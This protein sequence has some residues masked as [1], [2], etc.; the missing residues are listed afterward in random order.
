[1]PNIPVPDLAAMNYETIAD[2]I[3]TPTDIPTYMTGKQSG[4]YYGDELSPNTAHTNPY[5]H[6]K[7]N[8]DLGTDGSGGKLIVIKGNL[9][10]HDT[11]SLFINM[12][13]NKNQRVTIVVEGNLYIA[14]DLSY[15]N[16]NSAV[17]F[18]VKGNDANPESYVDTNRNYRYDPGESI[19]NDNG[20]GVYEGPIEGQ[21]NV[22]FGDPRFGTGG[23]TDGFIYAQNN[24]YLVNPPNNQGAVGGQDAIF[25]V[26]GFLSAGG[27]M[28]LGNRTAGDFYNNFRV[29]YDSRLQNGSVSFKG[30]PTGLGGGWN[31]ASVKAWRQVH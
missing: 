14:D 27:I 4:N 31:Q 5:F 10:L 20:N 7:V 22:F 11:S 28:D 17:L 9:W 30:M 18:I 15:N 24:V 3:V 12:P 25:G 26:F 6:M 29:K 8:M 1:M 13:A 23:V 16:P 2:R 19:L 21:G